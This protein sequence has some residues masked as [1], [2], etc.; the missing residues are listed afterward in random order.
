MQGTPIVIVGSGFA[1]LA[2]GIR[3]KQAGIHDFTIFE[4]AGRVGGTWRD[5]HYPGA[6]C[7]VESHLYSFSFEPN[8]R[9][10]RMFAPQAE[11]L[12]YL[13]HCARKY[14]LLPHIRLNTEVRSASFDEQEGTWQVET[15]D[16]RTTTARVV[17]S[18]CGGLSRPAWPDI[19]GLRVFGGKTFHSARWDDS[20]D[21]DGK[22]VAVIGTGASAIQIV[23]AIAP[24][25]GRLHLFQRTPPWILPK[26]DRAIAPREREWFSRVPL[27]QRLVE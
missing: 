9:W 17:V 14:G 21:L 27:L 3:L 11:I 20:A 5:N 26:W 18:A 7:D 16:G 8:P 12:A 15:S 6:A 25:V 24:K 13:E 2:M 1:G 23:P 22:T 19:P 4:Q 10:T